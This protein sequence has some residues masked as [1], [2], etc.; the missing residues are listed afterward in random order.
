MFR[1]EVSIPESRKRSEKMAKL[2]Q[3]VPLHVQVEAFQIGDIYTEWIT[4]PDAAAQRVILYLHGGGYVS[5]SVAIHKLLCA[6]LAQAAGMRILLPEYRLAPENPFPAALEDALSAYRWL[7]AQG[8]ASTDIIVA[9]DS[10][11]GGLGLAT[12]LALRG[13]GEPLPAVIVCISPWA[14]LTLSGGS[15]QTKAKSDPILYEKELRY[16][17]LSY[18]DEANLSNPLVSPLYA[19]YYGFPPMLIQVGSEEIL[20]DDAVT[21]AEKARAAGV[22]V[23]L[24]VYDGLWHVW[25][26]TGTWLPESRQALAEIGRF[27]RKYL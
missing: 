8:Y 21:V 3:K 1:K 19:D 13:T 12:L 22:D 7:L 2:F 11:G 16:W 5:G 10:A 17:A 6:A 24:S 20:L 18:T 9:G 15:H 27:V 25:H 23:T 4:P 14:D 26:A